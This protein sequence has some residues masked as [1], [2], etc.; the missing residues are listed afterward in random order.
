[1]HRP[2][3]DVGHFRLDRPHAPGLACGEQQERRCAPQL[4][5]SHHDGLPPHSGRRSC[6]PS[7][8][9]TVVCRVVHCRAVTQVRIN[10]AECQAGRAIN[11]M[12]NH[13][14]MGPSAC[15]T[16]TRGLCAGAVDQ[17][18]A[19]VH[20]PSSN[21]GTLV[22][23]R[24]PLIHGF[25]Q[26]GWFGPDPGG[27]A[28]T[29]HDEEGRRA[30]PAQ[31]PPPLP[32]AEEI[33]RRTGAEKV[34]VVG[35]SLGGVLLR[36]YV[37]E[38]GAIRLSTLRSRSPPHEGAIGVLFAVALHRARLRL[39]GHAAVA[40]V[41][42]GA[43]RW[44]ALYRLEYRPC[45]VN[46]PR[47]CLP[48]CHEPRCIASAHCRAASRKRP[49]RRYLRRCIEDRRRCSTGVLIAIGVAMRTT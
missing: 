10:D 36:W 7:G 47:T 9:R 43:V 19:V 33:R 28:V 16:G 8:P 30:G 5:Q 35:H 40:G 4:G 37:Q 14:S 32:A 29:I 18:G 22:P 17:L 11:R 13:G 39:L 25:T 44:V 12:S 31:D 26:P 48:T 20:L 46:E 24:K 3:D 38:M 2:E 45:W 1:M 34:H 6:P 42:Y 49:P 41:V 15:V 27:S 23:P 21:A